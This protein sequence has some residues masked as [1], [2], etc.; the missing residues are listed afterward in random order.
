MLSDRNRMAHAYNAADAMK[1]YESLNK[2]L[3]ELDILLNSL[4]AELDS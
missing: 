4:K 1:V 2:Y 3:P